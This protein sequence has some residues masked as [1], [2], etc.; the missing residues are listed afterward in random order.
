MP[1]LPEVETIRLGL[2]KY[3]VGKKVEKIELRLPKIVLEGSLYGLVGA[4]VERV[5]RFG[6]VLVLDFSPSA[7]DDPMTAGQVLSLVCHIKLTGQLVLTGVSQVV[8]VSRDKV[9][10]LPNPWTHLIVHFQD[11]VK[12]FYNDIRQFGWIRV[13]PSSEVQ[14]FKFIN[15]LGPEPDI[16]QAGGGALTLESLRRILAGKKTS[17]K[18]LLLDQ[19]RIGGVGNIYANDGLFLA[20]IDPKRAAGSLTSKEVEDLYDALLTV[21]KRGLEYGGAS[22]LTYVNALGGEG[23]YQKH[24]LVYAQNGK[25]CKK[26]GTKIEKI[27]LGGRGTYFCPECQK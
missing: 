22:E 5:R 26:C 6:K 9:G 4:M 19:S 11:G 13:L 15:E 14:N 17:I 10:T 3:L 18:T 25:P 16:A 23:E 8:Q 21:L 20:G 2:E 12:L 24:F 1:E 7:S 27:K